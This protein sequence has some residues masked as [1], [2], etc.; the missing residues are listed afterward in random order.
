MVPIP[1]IAAGALEIAAQG[2]LID[3]FAGFAVGTRA[4][5]DVDLLLARQLYLFG[6][7]GSV[8]DD[9]KAVLG[10]LESGQLDTD[11]SVYAVSG[12]EG[13]PDALAAVQA[14]TSG[15]KIVI[16]PQLR[17]LGLIRL[18]DMATRYPQVA[19]GLAEG[20]WTRRAE[21]ALLATAG[22]DAGG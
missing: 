9:M 16:Y 13:V 20:R 8:I 11:I 21:E 14:R 12:L 17:S 4:P 15:G 6:T 5:I 10:R 7:S 22:G 2:A 1:A 19:D 3:L 18:T